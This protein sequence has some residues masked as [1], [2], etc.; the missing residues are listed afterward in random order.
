MWIGAEGFDAPV[1][2]TEDAV[3]E[4]ATRR[5]IAQLVWD[6]QLG[7]DPLPPGEAYLAPL[8]D[9]VRSRIGA[10]AVGDGLIAGHDFYPTAVQAVGGPRPDWSVTD[11]VA[12]GAA[13]LVRWHDRYRV[14]FWIGETSNL[15]LPVS[16][17]VPWLD[18]LVRALDDLRAAGRPVRGVC[19]YSRGDQFDW[20]TA[21]ANPTG[22]VTEVGLFDVD[23]VARPV[24]ERFAALAADRHHQP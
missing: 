2:V 12:F 1:P 4:V 19:W 24:A 3:G 14:P 13:E 21:L 10:L 16:E 11:L 7:V 17:Q 20:Q 9:A 5:A 22:A 18:A 6:L 23:R 8:D 15:S